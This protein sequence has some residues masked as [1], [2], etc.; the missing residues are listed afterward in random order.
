VKLLALITPQGSE[1]VGPL[2][3]DKQGRRSTL[4]GSAGVLTPYEKGR[5]VRADPG[6]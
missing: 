1:R 5:H 2:P 6:T 3:V 4:G